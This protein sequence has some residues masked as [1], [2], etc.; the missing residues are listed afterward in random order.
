MIAMALANGPDV[1]IADEPTTALDVTIQAQIL[2][3]LAELQ[4]ERDMAM[5]LI[6]HDLGI[7]RGMAQRVA[8]MYAGEIVEVAPVQA[9]F[10]RPRHPYAQLLL[11]A[12]PGEAGRGAPLA[13]I[14]G[15]V[16]SLARRFDHCRFSDRCP[17]VHARCLAAPVP[18]LE[19]GPAHLARC[20]L[21]DEAA[22]GAAARAVGPVGAPIARAESAD[23]GGVRADA[24]GAAA[25][26]TAATGAASTARSKAHGVDRAAG[27]APADAPLLEV[28][29]LRVRFPI[30][31]GVLLR[32]VGHVDAVR[33][34][35]FS[36]PAGRTLALV[37]E[38]GSGKTTVAKAV[39]QLLRGQA[40]IE[41]TAS[42]LGR[43]LFGLSGATLRAAR[44]DVQIV[45]QDQFA[46]LDPRMTVGR[47]LD[48][49]MATLLPEL[50][51]TERARRAGELL[52]RVSLRRDALARYPHEFSGGQRQR[53]AIA[54][55]LAVGPRLLVCDEP[56][57][58]L[59]VSVQAQI[60]NL[61]RT[62]QQHTGVSYLF[63]THNL[64]VVEYLAD[65]VAVM[66]DGRI[67]EQ[68]SA[69]DVL[70]R[71]ADP[72]TRQLLAAVPRVWPSPV[73]G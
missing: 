59:D 18:M 54:R 68:G 30:R 19:A 35:S 32:T 72:Y 9:F 14:P 39:L 67:V 62:L 26:A 61:L 53:I 7:V 31:R 46:S 73:S 70:G 41:G 11:R 42:L 60:L 52:D 2:A 64:G 6:T 56:T 27:A 28:R 5:L 20:V 48:E 45:F 49:G 63:I 40:I 47:I 43:D 36:L 15:N 1:L 34:V 21:V 33:D 13:A 4:R 22:A 23:A 55:A 71:P 3:L 29:G 58:A 24:A 51:R 10:A 66:R 69:A 57:S 65:A 38:S 8:L 50:D 17:Q 12:L 25:G 44:R 37:G 16:P